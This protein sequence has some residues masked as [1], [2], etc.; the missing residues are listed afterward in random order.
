[1]KY[2]SKKEIKILVKHIKSLICDDYRA[3]EEDDIPGIQLT[4]G[5]TPETGKWDYQ[6]GD[7]SYSG[8]AYFHRNWAV[9]GVYRKSNCNKVADDILNQL[10]EM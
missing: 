4:I 5:H 3:F 7:N 1:M 2:P 8:G 9:V 10:I 6:I